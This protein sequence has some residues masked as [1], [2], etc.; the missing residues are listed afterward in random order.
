M[1]HRSL[2]SN[3]GGTK[4]LKDYWYVACAASRLKSAPLAARILDEDLAIF[5]DAAGQAH[6]LLDRCCHRGVKL[7]LGVVT[8]GNLACRY[9]GWQY[10]GTGRCVH[11]PSL[12]VDGR[13]PKGFEVRT[14]PCVEQDS[15]IWVWMGQGSPM[16]ASP[17]AIRDFSRFAWRQGCSPH[18]CDALKVI[19]NNIDLCH[20]PFA[21]AGNHALYFAMRAFG[22]RETETEV[23][24]TENGLVAFSPPAP[25]AE[26]AVPDEPAGITA[27]TLP[28]RVEI[29]NRYPTG[30]Y[31]VVMHFVP[32]GAAT[33]R[34]EWLWREDK[35]NGVTWVDEEP[36]L[37]TQDRVILE[38]SQPW[39]DRS[40]DDFERSV[41]ADH[42][43]LLVR[44][45]LRLAEAGQWESRRGSLARR[46][47]IRVRS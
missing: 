39:Y 24:V 45:V 12:T 38:S 27:F 10:D 23:R 15:Y 11:V 47:V 7:S 4:V 33:C 17:P 2:N 22:L 6:A 26:H 8:D 13:I 42:P 25:S 14:F 34:M 43:T 1:S 30:D 37:I 40:G 21:H 31:V 3:H 5:R 9:H 19:E 32:T 35:G 18:A 16:P 44:Q 28:N 41:E 36:K 29:R 20:P 46:R